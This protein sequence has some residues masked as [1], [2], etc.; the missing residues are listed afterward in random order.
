[1]D[2][3]DT[4]NS[5]QTSV[6]IHNSLCSLRKRP[7]VPV[8]ESNKHCL[9]VHPYPCLSNSHYDFDNVAIPKGF[10]WPLENTC[11]LEAVG[12]PDTLIQSKLSRH[13]PTEIWS[14][15][16]A[17]SL[18]WIQSELGLLNVTISSQSHPQTKEVR[19]HTVTAF[20]VSRKSLE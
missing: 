16:S 2:I 18:L 8:R 3:G 14:R 11:M 4:G 20:E 19:K 10:L 9:S 12:S 15:N 17:T 1:L 7:N 6:I 13:P 5:S